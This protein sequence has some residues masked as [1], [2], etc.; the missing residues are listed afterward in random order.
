MDCFYFPDL[1]GFKAKLPFRSEGFSSG[2]ATA[3]EPEHGAVPWQQGGDVG[4]RSLS[5]LFWAGG[6]D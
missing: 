2:L 3:S 5:S 1:T 4:E 6:V